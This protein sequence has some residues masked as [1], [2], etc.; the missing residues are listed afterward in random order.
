VNLDNLREGCDIT[1]TL[2]ILEAAPSL[3]ELCITVWDHRCGDVP[4][5][6][7][8]QKKDVKWKPC[9]SNFKHENLA[10]LTISG[11]QPDNNFVGYVARVMGAAVR[12]KE[13]SLHDRKVCK[14][15]VEDGVKFCPS[16]YPRTSEDKDLCIEKI[17]KK[18]VMGSQCCAINFRS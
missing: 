16:R 17:T 3:R 18:L 6:V 11:F 1:W 9:D 13:V 7:F 2:F 12:I 8:S 10:K 14:L 4:H 15:C 5:R